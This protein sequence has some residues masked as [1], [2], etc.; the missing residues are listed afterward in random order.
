MNKAY[1]EE[2]HKL[3]S[4]PRIVIY[5]YMLS[6]LSEDK[7]KSNALASII[8]SLPSAVGFYCSPKVARAINKYLSTKYS[9]ASEGVEISREWQK[10]FFNFENFVS[11]LKKINEAN[12]FF[13]EE[14]PKI[15]DEIIDAM[16]WKLE[17]GKDELLRP[18]N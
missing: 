17:I 16:C 9:K 4:A 15:F 1:S 12:I 11:Y 3:F 2:E 6:L 14:L 8:I 5:K 7:D 10:D 13:N 18:A